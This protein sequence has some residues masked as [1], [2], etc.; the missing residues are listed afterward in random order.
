MP[1][2]NVPEMHYNFADHRIRIARAGEAY[3]E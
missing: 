1:K 2:V 3:P